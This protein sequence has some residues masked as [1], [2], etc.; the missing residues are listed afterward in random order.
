MSI[1]EGSVLKL[2]HLVYI[3]LLL[4]LGLWGLSI[5]WSV[6]PD[7]LSLPSKAR[8]QPT[9]VATSD[10]LI[11]SIRV[12]LNK[13]GGFVSND[14]MPPGDIMDNMP[15]WEY[16]ALIELRAFTR[17]MRNDISRGQDQS[18]RDPDLAHAQPR[19]NVSHT[20]WMFP[21]AEG[22][23][24]DA[25]TDL[26]HYRSRLEGHGTP[27]AHF[28]A[29]ARDLRLWMEVVA[30]RLGGLAKELEMAGGLKAGGNALTR[31]NAK[32]AAGNQPST[33]QAVSW[34]QVDNLFYRARGSAWALLNLCRG[35]QVDFHQVL[36][37]KNALSTFKSLETALA[38]TQRPMYSPIVFSGDN[39]GL[40]ANH[41]LTM[42]AFLATADATA[43][44]LQSLMQQD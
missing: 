16:G 6:E 35:I 36:V 39:F 10:E 15:S 26:V 19:L 32:A 4:A 42:A 38:A 18:M 29:R 8:N 37:D 12:L 13:H 25:L 24:G 20:S 40:L 22:A 14:I 21:S 17:L 23:Y 11:D 34:W 28:Y 7:P 5:Y 33:P 44:N 9:G 43:I 1:L 30:R 41:T 31:P 27:V 3:L 2:R